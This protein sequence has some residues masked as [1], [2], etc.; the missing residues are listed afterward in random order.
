M[1][2]L[3]HNAKHADSILLKSNPALIWLK[4]AS[5]TYCKINNKEDL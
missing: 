1:R 5:C 4:S 3:K 2:T